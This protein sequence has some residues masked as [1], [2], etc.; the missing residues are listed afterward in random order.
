MLAR[1]GA[2]FRHFGALEPALTRPAVRTV[3]TAREPFVME[4]LWGWLL[5]ATG[6]WKCGGAC[7]DLLHA[8]RLFGKSGH[9][10]EAAEDHEDEPIC[11]SRAQR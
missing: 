5:L 4:V 7:P 2:T 1:F 11:R 10:L 8:T 3:R 9:Q 6:V